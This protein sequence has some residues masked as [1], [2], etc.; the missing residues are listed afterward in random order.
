MNKLAQFYQHGADIMPIKLLEKMDD[1][2]K[3]GEK[4]KSVLYTIHSHTNIVQFFKKN[5][6]SQ[7]RHNHNNYFSITP[8]PHITAIHRFY[9]D[10][11]AISC[12]EK[13]NFYKKLLLSQK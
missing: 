2:Q 1:F 5:E 13:I 7:S 12:P 4:N 9:R 10:D 11:C 8:T 3:L 6:L